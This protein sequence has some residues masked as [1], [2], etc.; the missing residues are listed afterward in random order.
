[1]TVKTLNDLFHETVKD[2]YYAEKKLVKSLPKMIKLATSPDLKHAIESH[3]EETKT[4][5]TRLEEVFGI[6]GKKPVAKKCEAIEG[7]L[8]EADEVVGEIEDTE[9]R[10]TGIISS[11][12]TVE[13]YE[14]SRY[15][16]L[17]A[18]ARQL[19]MNDAADLLEQTL[20][21]EKAADEKL[22]SIADEQPMRQA[23]E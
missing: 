14:I 18:W 20:E 9:V 17:V 7:L 23:A 21:E 22:T 1:M 3:L 11:A 2:I 19:D 8:K 16:T 10:D 13:H 15:G 12:Q 4:H 5:I 6:M